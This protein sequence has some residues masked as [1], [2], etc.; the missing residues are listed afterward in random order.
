LIV[1]IGDIRR[2]ANADKLAIF[3]GV[4]LV[5][6]SS[7]RKGK[8]QSARQGNRQLHGLFYFLAITTVLVPKNRV[9]N[10]PIS[11]DYYM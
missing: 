10:H 6:F 7:A 9:P 8:E 3:K 2:F 11:Y 5:K 1:E 4:A